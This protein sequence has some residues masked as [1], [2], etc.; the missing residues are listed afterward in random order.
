MPDGG[1]PGRQAGGQAGA[2][3]VQ[4]ENVFLLFSLFFLSRDI[5]A[6]QVRRKLHSV[7]VNCDQRSLKASV[8]KAS[9]CPAQLRNNKI[10]GVLCRQQLKNNTKKSQKPGKQNATKNL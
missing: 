3:A 6:A 1:T 9:Q 7:A 5:F 8:V 2:R 4:N 10:M